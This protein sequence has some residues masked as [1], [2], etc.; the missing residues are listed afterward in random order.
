VLL[1]AGEKTQRDAERDQSCW[2]RVCVEEEQ[3]EGS[4]KGAEAWERRMS[5]RGDAVQGERTFVDCK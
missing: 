3:A 1:D 2:E 5:A 4:S